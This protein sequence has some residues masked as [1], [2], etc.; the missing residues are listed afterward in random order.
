VLAATAAAALLVPLPPRLPRRRGPRVP[1]GRP[2]APL[3]LVTLVAWLPSGW[4]VPSAIGVGAVCVGWL[5]WLRRRERVAAA[6]TGAR[7]LEAC[8]HLACEL[9]SGQPPGAALARAADAWPDLAP[10][11]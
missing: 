9:A 2:L 3:L 4:L 10:V 5:L 6:E 1:R 7:V 8:E 11:A